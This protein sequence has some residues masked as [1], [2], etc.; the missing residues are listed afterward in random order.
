MQYPH[1]LMVAGAALVVLGLIG[2]AV[3]QKREVEL[4]RERTEMKASGKRAGQDSNATTLPP[5]PWRLP[6]QAR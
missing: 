3:R 5:W 6:P 1:W 4:D 2:L